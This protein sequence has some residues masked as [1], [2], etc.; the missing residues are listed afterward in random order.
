MVPR[1]TRA[2]D[3][4]SGIVAHEW[5]QSDTGLE[6]VEALLKSYE[7]ET[8]EGKTVSGDQLANSWLSPYDVQS[9]PF[10]SGG[11]VECHHVPFDVNSPKAFVANTP[12]AEYIPPTKSKLVSTNAPALTL[13]PAETKSPPSQ[14][15]DSAVVPP[16]SRVR[17]KV[18]GS[19]TDTPVEPASST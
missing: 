12:E 3:E 11:S 14:V 9:F 19:P 10:A 1:P 4:G 6:Y 16:L 15:C 13:I 18:K 2:R 8:F 5:F 7:Y 17:V